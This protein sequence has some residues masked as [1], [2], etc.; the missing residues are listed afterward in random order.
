MATVEV[1]GLTLHSV[2]YVCITFVLYCSRLCNSK[3]MYECL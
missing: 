3:W 1:K 2:Y